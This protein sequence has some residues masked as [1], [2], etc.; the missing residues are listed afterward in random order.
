MEQNQAPHRL[1]L[2]DDDVGI[3]RLLSD[4]LT[5]EGY[6]VVTAA[7]GREAI[8][9]LAGQAPDLVVMDLQMPGVNGFEVL[10]QIRRQHAAMPVIV[11]T[12]YGSEDVAVQALRRGADD[13]LPKPLRLGAL[14]SRIR[15]NLERAAWRAAQERA[16]D[17]FRQ[18]A[19]ELSGQVRGFLAAAADVLRAVRD[20][21]AQSGAAPGALEVV[22]KL[23]QAFRADDPAAAL[24]AL[25]A[26]LGAPPTGSPKSEGRIPKE[27]REPKP[28]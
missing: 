23:S 19:I 17:R 2:I 6:V 7:G 11:V 9:S 8:A 27:A 28:E 20:E 26:E 15:A 18:S 24:R 25:T 4:F 22:E 5:K 16:E 1:L 13:Y 10:A 14:A 21:L 3:L 12:G